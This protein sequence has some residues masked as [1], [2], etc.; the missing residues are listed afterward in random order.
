M[1]YPNNPVIKVGVKGE[2][3]EQTL[4]CFTVLDDGAKDTLRGQN[5]LDLFFA[6]LSG[7]DKDKVKDKDGDK[8]KD[9]EEDGG[10][11]SSWSTWSSWLSWW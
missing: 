5:G 3:N 6:K 10:S 11:S 2:W 1:R 7:S 8:D 4:G 9:G